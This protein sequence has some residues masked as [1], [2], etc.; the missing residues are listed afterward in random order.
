MSF[1]LLLSD[2][3]ETLFLTRHPQYFPMLLVLVFIADRLN[4]LNL[5]PVKLTV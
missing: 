2:L 3:T 5:L 4:E 1:I